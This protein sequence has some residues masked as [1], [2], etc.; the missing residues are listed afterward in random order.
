M[1]ATPTR[2]P[3]RGQHRAF[4]LF[5]ILATFGTWF[6]SADVYF[7]KDD[8]SL[9]GAMTDDAGGF[10]FE[11]WTRQLAWPTER[12]WDDIWRPIPAISWMIDYQLFGPDPVAFHLGNFFL[13]ALNAVLIYWLLARLTRFRRLVPAFCGALG[14]A[15]YPLHPEAVIWTTQRT[16]VMGMAF[17]LIG[18]VAYDVWLHRR[19]RSAL[20]I[21][22]IGFTLG[23]LSREH[24]AALPAAFVFLS[25]FFGPERAF[26][27][28]FGEI[29]R[30]GL[31]GTA[32]LVAWFGC[33]YLIFGR[34]AGGYSGW[35]TMDA[36]AADLQIFERLKD[37]VRICLAPGNR[38]LLDDHALFGVNGHVAFLALQAAFWGLVGWALIGT[39]LRHG[40]ALVRVFLLVVVFSVTA[41][42]P[43]AKVFY[44][45]ENLINS[46]SGYHLFALFAAFVPFAIAS[47]WPVRT[48]IGIGLAAAVL[49]SWTVVLQVNLTAYEG[50]GDQVRQV[51]EDLAA[52]ALEEGGDV[53]VILLNSPSHYAGCPTI[54][55]YLPQVMGPPYCFGSLPVL[56]L[57][58]G[59]NATWSTALLAPGA[60]GWSGL[61]GRA[62][63]GIVWRRG[64]HEEPWVRPMF[65]APEAPSGAVVAALV[66]P[67]AGDALVVE[68]SGTILLPSGPILPGHTTGT[69]VPKVD[70]AGVERGSDLAGPGYPVL[71]TPAPTFVFRLPAPAARVDLVLDVP[72][73]RLV[74]ELAPPADGKPFEGEI[75]FRLGEATRQG[76]QSIPWPLPAEMFAFGMPVQWR[77]VAR[78]AEGTILGVSPSSRFVFLS[79]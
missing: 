48:R 53:A 6:A 27:D 20:V 11:L 52:V 51:Q 15:L 9:R 61:A 29:V 58:T 3:W 65:G 33:R 42:L 57:V 46:R 13:H 28:R 45:E 73:R 37:T 30:V 54:E 8:L 70:R 5:I 77:V 43:V 19:R 38:D 12:T 16:V 72:D 31:V 50:G 76:G 47:A 60:M 24:A 21:A 66:A 1:D 26:R 7:I 25:T 79:E 64:G 44:V 55:A 71:R 34:L 63:R 40:A 32:I 17:C 2:D 62:S 69:W 59:Q 75:V 49:V 14:F 68:P 10:D 36:Y 22:W 67:R 23:L 41:W 56:G 35:E 39:G 74:S 78:D 18:L 4:L